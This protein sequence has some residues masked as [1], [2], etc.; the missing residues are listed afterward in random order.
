MKYILVAAVATNINIY[1]ISLV[2]IYVFFIYI[3]NIV[4]NG[5]L[6]LFLIPSYLHH[7][8]TDINLITLDILAFT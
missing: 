8:D 2:A 5:S 4:N 6:T 3:K 7:S 1:I